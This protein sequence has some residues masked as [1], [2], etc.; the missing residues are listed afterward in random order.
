[1]AIYPPILEGVLPPCYYDY[2]YNDDQETIT[3]LIFNLP[4]SYSRG[5]NPNKISG[6]KIL[7][8][9]IP[10]NNTIYQSDIF[11]IS[12]DN[13]Y[14]LTLQTE[15]QFL[16]DH[17]HE[18]QYYKI[19]MA[20][21]DESGQT[22]YWSTA[23]VTK[24]IGLPQ[25][26]IEYQKNL[27]TG[28][29]TPNENDLNETLYSSYFVL[30]YNNNIVEQSPEI[31]HKYI[32]GY[33]ESNKV[34]EYYTLK[35]S[36]EYGKL[37]ELE[38]HILTN[39][40]YS[41]TILYKEPLS[42]NDILPQT[43]NL[44]PLAIY[45]RENAYI[46]IGIKQAYEKDY[47]VYSYGNYLIQRSSDKD[48]YKSWI[49]IGQVNEITKSQISQSNSECILYQ[50]FNLEYGVTYKYSLQEI[51]P[52]NN[53]SIR[54]TSD[55]ITVYF[56]DM[57][58]YDETK[59]LCIRYN[60]T[61]SSFKSVV[62]EQ[63]IDPLGG[64]YPI[65]SRNGEMEYKEFTI[66]GLISYLVDQDNLFNKKSNTYTTNLSDENLLSEIN[67]RTEVLDWL[68]NGEY[69]YFK[70]P[71]EGTTK[72]RLMN[73]SLSPNNTLGRMLHTFQA[74]AYEIGE[75][76]DYNYQVN[77]EILNTT[78]S[79]SVIFS[80]SVTND[81]RI[82]LENCENIVFT[83]IG[84]T[85]TPI[86][87][88]YITVTLKDINETT[89]N[90]YY[91]T[92]AGLWLNEKIEGLKTLTFSEL[93]NYEV[94]FEGYIKSTS[95][96]ETNESNSTSSVALFT[97]TGTIDT[98]LYYYQL[99]VIEKDNNALSFKE[100]TE[101]SS[102]APGPNILR[103]T[104]SSFK[105]VNRAV[106]GQLLLEDFIAYKIEYGNNLTVNCVVYGDLSAI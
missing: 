65:F 52:N 105:T 43:Y 95:T 44:Q 39:N 22:G 92:Q 3:K 82:A 102:T 42:N 91:I 36:L 74:T 32:D 98:P 15:T 33:S 49:T 70:S 21:V 103:I 97:A 8:K 104:D 73:I 99:Q 66:S 28:I 7:I 75:I 53:L 64:K 55:L 85:N 20:F 89:I 62:Q 90:S 79:N 78:P 86:D 16:T 93:G 54:S 72:V 2:E 35:T 45:N 84:I 18:G 81:D 51:L 40:G 38:W 83:S 24:L 88:D 19:Q 76:N 80:L 94:Y 6:I 1:M 56:D 9:S 71:I 77:N 27:C 31:I 41:K 5:V 23:G 50:D 26:S 60:P 10:L 58:L 13:L 47:N 67:F 34:N 37:Y 68:N 57:F 61:V 11:S 63:K 48:N 106:V 14:K 59:Q 87:I 100:K 4:Y 25:G 69:K 17:M 96:E 12:E 30:K 29:Y 46:K 101:S